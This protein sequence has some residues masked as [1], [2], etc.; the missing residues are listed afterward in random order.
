LIAANVAARYPAR[1]ASATLVAGPFYADKATFN[2]EVAPWVAD[3]ESGKGLANFLQWLLPKMDAK[4]AA[5]A[6]LLALKTND[7]PS[8]IAVLR[9][10]PELTIAG[11][12]SADV[13]TLVVVGS[14]DPLHPLAAPFAKATGGA[15]ALE[16]QGAD[17][18]NVLASPELIRAMRELIQA[19][20]TKTQPIRD[21]A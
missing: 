11:L 16:L 6:S 7:L 3:L 9:S 13:P 18:I 15:R 8:L 17:H 1:V 2:K 10:L 19:A 20:G 21:A 4:M 5:G 14:G 12:G